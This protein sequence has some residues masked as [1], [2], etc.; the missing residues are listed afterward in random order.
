MSY[1]FIIEIGVEELPAIPLLKELKNIKEK[2][3]KVLENNKILSEFDFYYT[4]R[5][6]VLAH[7]NMKNKQED[8]DQEFFG[9]PKSIAFKDGKLS[10]AGISFAKKHN[11]DEDK[12]EFINK[13]GKDILYYKQEI[14][15]KNLEDL[16]SNILN[17]FLKSLHFGKM[18]RWGKIKDSFIRPIRWIL[19]KYE[20][21]TIKANCFNISSSNKSYGH[22]NISYEPFDVSDIKSYF[23]L[24][25]EHKVILNQDDRKNIIIKDIKKLE[26]ENNIKVEIDNDLLDEIVAITEYPSALLG[27][28]DKEFLDLPFEAV[29]TS[30]KEHQRYFAVFSSDN[31]LLNN[32]IVVSNLASNNQTKVI[33]GNEKVLK[34]RLQDAKFF[35]ENDIK[36]KLTNDGLEN[37]VFVNKLGSVLDKVKRESKIVNMLSL[38]YKVDSNITSRA[39]ELSK[40]DLLS[41]MVYEFTELQGIMGY[42][43]ALKQGEKEEVAIAIKEQYLTGNDDE[44]MPSNIYSAL[45]SISSKLDLVFSLFSIDMIPT[46][47]KDPYGLRRASIAIIHIVHKFDL[48]FDL[49]NI[50]NNINNIYDNKVSYDKL[51]KFF[52]ERFIGLNKMDSIKA[53]KST[54]NAVLATDESNINEIIKK[55]DALNTIVSQDNF[56]KNFSFIK[57]ISNI[58]NKDNQI[59]EIDI[60]LFE[61]EYEKNLYNKF[62]QIKAKTFN[63]YLDKLESLFLLEPELSSFFDNVMVNADNQNIKNNR[64]SLL[65]EINLEFKSI[66]D[67]KLISQ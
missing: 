39:T 14:I 65:S 20:D 15:G 47:S 45:V 42:Y 32:F 3:K 57:R 41:E 49:S 5:R 8:Y 38:R 30:M 2:Y 19:V 21:K 29:I 55:I 43:Y 64:I 51:K 48:D 50:H 24:L 26:K 13:N 31:K 36:N 61:N 7:T 59:C 11:I 56:K 25:S 54:I 40:A 53:N 10:N 27:T 6:L 1:N 44:N 46:G 52:N 66:A 4:P 35:Y 58:L 22:R 12:L 28:F 34:A 62:K 23:E 9:A 33:L 37:I 63:N 17:D 18:M 60:S 67:I 16:I